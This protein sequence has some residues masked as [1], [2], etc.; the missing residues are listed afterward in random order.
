MKK[1]VPPSQLSLDF[2]GKSSPPDATAFPPLAVEV[3]KP[4]T[5]LATVISFPGAKKPV[6]D[7]LGRILRFA[8]SLPKP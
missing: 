7:A 3:A 4:P 2:Q 5:E 1:G 8:D 6:S